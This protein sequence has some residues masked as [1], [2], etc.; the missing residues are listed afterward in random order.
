LF[1]GRFTTDP[2]HPNYDVAPQGKSFIMLRPVEE[3]RS[4]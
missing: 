3:H 1:E 2:W 4:W